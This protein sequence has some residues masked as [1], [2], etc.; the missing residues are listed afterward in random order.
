[1]LVA[2]KTGTDGHSRHAL[3]ADKA[4][5]DNNEM[6]GLNSWGATEPFM[7]ITPDNFL[8]SYLVD[9]VLLEKKGTVN[10][11]STTDPT[12]GQRTVPIPDVTRGYEE[13][14]IASRKR[15]RSL[16]GS[17]SIK[18]HKKATAM[19]S[20]RVPEDCA[21]LENAVRRVHGDRRLTTI[22][23]GE[24]EHR[25]DGNDVKISSAMNIVGDP[26]R[27]NPGVPKSE[28]VVMGGIRFKEGIQGN[29]H[30]QHLTL[31]AKGSS[32]VIGESSF[33]MKDV[34]V[35][36]CGGNGVGAWGTGVTVRC[37]NVEVRQCTHS[38][39]IAF[40]G[41]SITLIGA[42]TTVHHNC[43]KGWVGHY[44][45]IA[46]DSSAPN[47]TIQLVFPLT[48]ENVSVDNGGSGNSW[49]WN[50]GAGCSADINQIKTISQY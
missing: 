6:R 47:S 9:P 7:D 16:S 21:T 19:D 50:W 46:C 44:G 20:V 32:G 34:L 2:I 17:Y 29:C 39:V 24:G 25:I 12:W 3:A 43:T 37:T 11:G 8:H 45:L 31:Q 23:L 38:G 41:G 30:L 33:T 49:N 5:Q 22:I 27:G 36:Q 1:L 15:K 48:K 4:Y 28:I 40:D 13:M 18:N 42:K 26:G 10:I 35:E 14:D